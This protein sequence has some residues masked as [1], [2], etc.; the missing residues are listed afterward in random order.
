[1]VKMVNLPNFPVPLYPPTIL[2]TDEEKKIDVIA[3]RSVNC[4]SK[5]LFR[6][7]G[8]FP[9]GVVTSSHTNDRNHHNR[10]YYYFSFKKK[11]DLFRVFI[12]LS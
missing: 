7:A 12:R 2:S 11:L 3:G 9:I 6:S 1:M 8:R 5:K 4:E 10:I